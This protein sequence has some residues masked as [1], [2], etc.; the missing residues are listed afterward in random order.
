MSTSQVFPVITAP[1]LY[2]QGFPIVRTGNTTITIGS[3]QCRD[4]N[5]VVDLYLNNASEVP[6]SSYT[7]A[8]LTLSI[9][10]VGLNGVDAT[11][12]ASTFYYVYLIG[13]SNNSQPIAAIATASSTG[14]IMPFGYDSSRRIGFFVLDSSVHIILAYISGDRSARKFFYDSPIA[15][16][17]TAGNATTYTAITLTSLVPA[18]DNLRVSASIAFT[19]GSAARQAF[20]QGGNSTGDQV[21]VTGQVTSVLVT[22]TQEILSQLVS[23]VSKINYKVTNAGD[24]VAINV[25]GFIFNL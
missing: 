21:K 5:N 3:G 23:G 11:A 19:P 8:P 9:G 7:S 10:T 24:A 14:P 25:S 16:S 6:D 18:V 12:T 2:I 15:T 13:A 1:N 20:L 4:S 22:D 17:V